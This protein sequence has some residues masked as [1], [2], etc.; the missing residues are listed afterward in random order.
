MGTSMGSPA[1]PAI[2]ALTVRMLSQYSRA[3]EAPLRGSQYSMM[4]SST[5]SRVTTD[6]R[7]PSQSVQAWNFSTIHAHSAAGES[8]SA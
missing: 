4:L 6:S 1:S 3:A 2:H 7:S 8:T 5:S